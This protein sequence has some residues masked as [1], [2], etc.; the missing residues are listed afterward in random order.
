MH[1]SI[2]RHH[3]RHRGRRMLACSRGVA[4]PSLGASPAATS[5]EPKASTADARP[6]PAPSTRST[7]RPSSAPTALSIFG[8][9]A[10][11]ADADLRLRRRVRHRRRRATSSSIR[12]AHVA[13]GA[14]G[15]RTRVGAADAS[16]AR[17]TRSTQAPQTGYR[18][19]TR[20][21][22]S[23]VGDAFVI[24]SRPTRPRAASRSTGQRSVRQDRQSTRVDPEATRYSPHTFTVDPNCGFSSR[25][26]TAIPK[27]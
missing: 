5:R 21:S 18:A 19:D 10:R 2:R 24:A 22:R 1:S 23:N 6:T 14:R 26:L 3:A 8:R 25:S 15:R 4:S 9:H 27:D 17:S 12:C 7:A 20:C 16:P 13:G 11:A